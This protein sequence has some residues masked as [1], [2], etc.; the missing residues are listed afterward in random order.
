[1][2]DLIIIGH[3]N[4]DFGMEVNNFSILKN[5]SGGYAQGVA[6]SVIYNGRRMELMELLNIVIGE[7][8]NTKPELSLFNLPN[9]GVLY[10]NNFVAK[11]GFSVEIINFFNQGKEQLKKLLTRN[12]CAVAITTTFYTDINPIIEIVEF[13][14]KHNACT[15]III[16]GPYI[17]YLCSNFNKEK[18]DVWLDRI[19][20]DIFVFDSQGETA[21][22]Q[23]LS[24]L[25]N[26]ISPELNSIPNLIF[27]DR[28]NSFVETLRQPEN[29]D[30]DKNSIDWR[31]FNRD[32]IVP[33]V[34]IR[35]ARGCSFRCAFCRYP[36]FAGPV[37]FL[38]IDTLEK[39]MMALKERE[40]KNISIIDDTLNVPLP[41]F[42]EICK[43]ML[44]NNFKF[45]WFSNFRC[46]HADEEAY[47]LMAESGCKGVFVGIESGDQTILNNMNKYANLEKNRQGIKQLNKRN[48]ITFASVIVGFPGE[49]QETINNTIK[50][51]E[52]TKPLF[53]RPGLFF[54][55]LH[56]PV[57]NRAKEFSLKGEGYRWEHSTMNWKQACSFIKEM[58]TSVKNSTILPINGFDFWCIPY[59]LGKGIS[60]NQFIAFT[61]STQRFLCKDF[62]EDSFDAKESKIAMINFLKEKI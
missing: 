38:S 21:L 4:T 41:R 52:E 35:T 53:W 58:F 42:K 44:K 18:R 59:L 31:I 26:N 16:G 28:S 19:G 60:L 62:G 50:F 10:L 32:L 11:R 29:N 12:P 30:L 45:N 3:N 39:E 46:S 24:A 22:S 37:S 40:V 34:Q 33:N 7:A 1:M 13:I 23:I 57:H 6:N 9:L 54:Y 25:K 8:T 27:K 61:K 49:T 48:I 51:I 55:D 14:K 20:A 47:D 5:Y 56:A 15:K 36:E 17:F 2:L 43:M